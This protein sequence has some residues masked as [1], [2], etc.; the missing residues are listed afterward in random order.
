MAI[1]TKFGSQTLTTNL[2]QTAPFLNSCTSLRGKQIEHERIEQEIQAIDSDLNTT[3]LEPWL[4]GTIQFYMLPE[5]LSQ[6]VLQASLQKLEGIK[7][8]K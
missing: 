4:H 6:V 3:Q 7:K 8:I 2:H 5:R 1:W